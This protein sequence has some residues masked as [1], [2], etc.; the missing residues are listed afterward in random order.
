MTGLHVLAAAVVAV[1]AVSLVVLAVA[2]VGL[3]R[4]PE[5]TVNRWADRGQRV[6]LLPPDELRRKLAG[7]VRPARLSDR[8]RADG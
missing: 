7:G 4:A 8:D 2:V 5:R 1:S 3:V 6:N